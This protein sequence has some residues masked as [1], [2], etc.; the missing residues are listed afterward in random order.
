M[1]QPCPC[2]EK[3]H[4]FGGMTLTMRSP[5]TSGFAAKSLFPSRFPDLPAQHHWK[6]IR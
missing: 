3:S 4:P 2:T 5:T 1:T 6:S